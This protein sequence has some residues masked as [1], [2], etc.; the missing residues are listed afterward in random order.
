MCKQKVPA[1]LNKANTYYAASGATGPPT[2]IGAM[3][4]GDGFDNAFSNDIMG[5]S[6]DS[7]MVRAGRVPGQ[8]HKILGLVKLLRLTSS[9]HKCSS[10]RKVERRQH[11]Q[12]RP[13]AS[14]GGGAAAVIATVTA[15]AAVTAAATVTRLAAATATRTRSPTST[16]R[17]EGGSHMSH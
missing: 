17:F 7:S 1:Y 9:S 12:S 14:G 5:D 8:R 10:I 3:A 11:H 2:G 16:R 4:P 6:D 13:P 15:A